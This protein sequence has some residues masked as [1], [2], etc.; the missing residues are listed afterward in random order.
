MPTADNTTHVTKFQN[1]PKYVAYDENVDQYMEWDEKPQL[2]MQHMYFLHRYEQPLLHKTKPSCLIAIIELRI[3][4]VSTLCTSTLLPNAAVPA[5]TQLAPGQLLL[6]EIDHYDLYCESGRHDTLS[7]CKYCVIQVPCACRLQTPKFTYFPHYIACRAQSSDE[8]RDEPTIL[9]PVNL[10]LLEQFFNSSVVADLAQE[11]YFF[12]KPNISIPHFNTFSSNYTA[13]IA[14]LHQ[15]Q[16]KLADVANQA[17]DSSSIFQ[18]ISHEIYR[19][20]KET[21]WEMTASSLSVFNWQSFMLLITTVLSIVSFTG[22]IILW[23]RQGLLVLTPA[24]LAMQQ[25]GIGKALAASPSPRQIVLDYF[26]DLPSTTPEPH[27]WHNVLSSIEIDRRLDP[28]N[29]L[30]VIGAILIF[31]YMIYRIYH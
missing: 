7:G 5:I 29:I 11:K 28:E 30:A 20:M 13:V 26:K 4:L 18:Q 22:L 27:I 8:D 21:Q 10:M 25:L 24:T 16:L 9:F 17:K 23:R 31:I 19:E 6:Q 2:D 1:L 12:R 15:N 3:D 14:R